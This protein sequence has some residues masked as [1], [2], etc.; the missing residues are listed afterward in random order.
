MGTID[1]II[2]RSALYYLQNKFFSVIPVN[3]SKKPL[4]KWQEYQTRLPDKEEI[5][6]WFK[7]YPSANIGIV[8]GKVSNLMVVDIDEEQGY[9]EIKKYIPADMEYPIVQTPSGGH[10]Y[11]FR[12]PTDGRDV[13]LN[14]RVIPGCDLRA[15]GGYVVAPPSKN[16][17]GNYFWL[18]NN[19][20]DKKPIP[21]IPDSY[22]DFVTTCHNRH[23]SSQERHPLS[24]PSAY[25]MFQKGRRDNDIFHVANCLVK[26]GMQ[27]PEIRQVLDILGNHCKFPSEELDIKIASAMQRAATRERNLSQEL[28]EYL[29]VTSGYFSVTDCYNALQVVTKCDKAAIRQ[30]LHRKAS[31]DILEKHGLRAATYRMRETDLEEINWLEADT[32]EFPFNM[33][34]GIGDFVKIMPKNLIVV[35]GSPDSGKTALLLNM[36]RSNMSLYKNKINYFSSEM[37]TNEM[38]GRLANFDLPLNAWNFKAFNRCGNFADVIRPDEINII[39]FLELHDEFWKVGGMLKDIYEK[40]DKGIAVIAL[41][42][43]RGANVGKGGDVTLEKPRLYLSME[44][45][46][47]C[48]EKGKNWRRSEVNPNNLQCEFKLVKGCKFIMS[49]GGWN[50]KDGERQLDNVYRFPEPEFM[51]G[52]DFYAQN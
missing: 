4:I 48:I 42:K 51:S 41:Q 34:L 50:Y 27:Q 15:D 6:D 31:A 1:N 39:D 5:R 7:R 9:E 13:R 49:A 44:G 20:I 36:V 3:D 18:T 21:I 11:Y 35:A 23:N 37:S 16:Q 22:V 33:P 14:V 29:V 26:G 17:K 47:I 24:Q 40:L 43:K 46:K 45:G 32:D 10:H 25:E 8:T 52:N 19:R 30:I 38:K 12:M 2:E 28:E